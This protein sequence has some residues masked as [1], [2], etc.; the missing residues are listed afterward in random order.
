MLRFHLREL[1]ADYQFR[2]GTRLTLIA[3]SAATGIHRTTLTKLANQKG[4]NA[5]AESIDRLCKFFDCPVEALVTR[6]ADSP[7]ERVARPKKRVATKKN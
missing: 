1:I 4:Y 6:V 5:T 3:L 7:T 2:H